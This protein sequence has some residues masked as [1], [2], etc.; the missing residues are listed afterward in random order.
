M[1]EKWNGIAG[2]NGWLDRGRKKEKKTDAQLAKK[3]FFCVFFTRWRSNFFKGANYK[4]ASKIEV[5]LK[6]KKN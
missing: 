2:M 3:K 4:Y 1:G 6:V 5:C